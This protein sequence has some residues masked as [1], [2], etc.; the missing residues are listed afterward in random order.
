MHRTSTFG[1]KSKPPKSHKSPKKRVKTKKPKKGLNVSQSG[2]N[3]KKTS[4]QNFACSAA[5]LDYV[6]LPILS[7]ASYNYYT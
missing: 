3:K 2:G 4:E 7:L 6:C 5:F 1:R